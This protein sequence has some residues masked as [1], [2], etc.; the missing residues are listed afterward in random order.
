MAACSSE[1]EQIALLRLRQALL[2]PEYPGQIR[3]SPGTAN[4][5]FQVNA[6]KVLQILAL[7]VIFV[8]CDSNVGRPFRPSIPLLRFFKITSFDPL[9]VYSRR[10]DADFSV[11]SLVHLS[12]RFCGPLM[13][14]L[15]SP[16][17][18]LRPGSLRSRVSLARR[19]QC[20]SCHSSSMCILSSTLAFGSTKLRVRRH[21]LVF[22][23]RFSASTFDQTL[24][25]KHLNIFEPTITLP[26]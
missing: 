6:W 7:S 13:G 8:Y 17:I 9:A 19:F 2:I 23:W 14:V 4:A 10:S 16:V 5:F 22:S 24:F 1:V 21:I 18:L 26:A 3:D 15:W 12:A 20:S 25:W 11:L